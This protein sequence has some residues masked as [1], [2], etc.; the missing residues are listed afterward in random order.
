MTKKQ[1]LSFLILLLWLALNITQSALVVIHDDI[2]AISSTSDPLSNWIV[3]LYELILFGSFPLIAVV[4]ALN[5]D[6]LQKLN[7]DKLY[8]ILL[9]IA[10]ILALYE[11]PFNCLNGVAF[12]YLVHAWLS[13]KVKFG[14]PDPVALRISLWVVGIFA[15]IFLMII[16][17]LDMP[18]I[19][20]NVRYFIVELTPGSIFEEAM[21]RGLLFM[22]LKDLRFGESKF[23]YTQ[24]FIFWISHINYL[25]Q[26]PLYFWIFIPAMG[27]TLGYIVLRTKSIAVSAITHILMNVITVALS[28][29]VGAL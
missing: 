8:V 15:F 19:E 12:I 16:G 29:S 7:I 26:G 27:L 18:K 14:S 11:L 23:L 3:V 28:L 6:D 20:Q 9:L 22:F 25:F 2:L 1:I 13:K 24:A 17:L 4:I 5:R 10:G 21:Y